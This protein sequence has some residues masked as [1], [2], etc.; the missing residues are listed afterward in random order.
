MQPVNHVIRSEEDLMNHFGSSKQLEILDLQKIEDLLQ[1]NVPPEVWEDVSNRKLLFFSQEFVQKTKEFTLNYGKIE[2]VYLISF[3]TNLT[4]LDLSGNKISDI[5]TISKLK[6]LKTLDLTRNCIEDIPALQSLPD[7][8]HL[9]LSNNILTSYTLALPNLVELFLCYNKLQD[10]SGLQHSPK[11]QKLNLSGTE[12]T[13]L[14]T[15]PPQLFGLKELDLFGNMITQISHLSNFVDLQIL[16][17][18]N[19]EQ[20][21]NIGPLQFCPQLIDL[22]IYETNVTDIWPLQFMKNLKRLSIGYAKVI[23][24][25]PL[26]HLYKLES[27]SAHSTCILDVSPLQK[28]TQLNSLNVSCNKITNTDTLQ[29][30]KNFSKYNFQN[31]EVPKTDELKFYSKILSVHSSHK[32]IVKLILA[33]NRVSKFRKQLN[34]WTGFFNVRNKQ[35]G[36]LILKNIN[37]DLQ[38]IIN[39]IFQQFLTLIYITSFVDYFLQFFQNSQFIVNFCLVLQRFQY[40][41]QQL[42]YF[43]WQSRII[44]LYS[45]LNTCYKLNF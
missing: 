11:L 37:I 30:H 17:L 40:I 23:D 26:Q 3:L 15:I 42:F 27:I 6:N 28:L 10:K 8:T 13:D 45:V 41:Y 38:S 9:Y 16:C 39:F 33:E 25:H 34:M 7:L 2:H 5:S 36:E 32:Q 14:R 4:E 19:N 43:H 31:Q 18:G 29:H 24:L 20:L 1:M 12:T 22:R 44:I 35:G 21:Q